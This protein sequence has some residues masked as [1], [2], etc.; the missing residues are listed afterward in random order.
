[1]VQPLFFRFNH[2]FLDSNMIMCVMARNCF[3][4]SIKKLK[5][6][7]VAYKTWM[8]VSYTINRIDSHHHLAGSDEVRGTAETIIIVTVWHIWLARIDFFLNSLPL[9]VDGVAEN[10]KVNVFL[11][12][13][14][15]ASRL[16]VV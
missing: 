5:L 8:T 12:L 1:M 15:R 11:W 14:Y 10:I 4:L 16:N 9:S 13:R 2:Q 3:K 7:C 6:N